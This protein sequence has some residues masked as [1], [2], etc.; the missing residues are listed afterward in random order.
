MKSCD[1]PPWCRAYRGMKVGRYWAT[2]YPYS[3]RLVEMIC[4][5]ENG[6]GASLAR[7]S[8]NIG[9]RTA[10]TC[11]EPDVRGEPGIR[12]SLHLWGQPTFVWAEIKGSGSTWDNSQF[13]RQD[14][15]TEQTGVLGQTH[16][17]TVQ[18]WHRRLGIGTGA[19][20]APRLTRLLFRTSRFIRFWRSRVR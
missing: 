6:V 1:G 4:R 8:S 13:F 12:R 10:E 15:A 17:L 18:D 19:S 7:E 16:L 11:H 14:R 9:R 2:R 20:A 5:L 3:V